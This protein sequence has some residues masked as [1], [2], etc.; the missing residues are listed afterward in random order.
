M[1][2]LAVE[3]H[4]HL[5]PKIW[6]GDKLKSDIET[7]LKKIADV[8]IDWCEVPMKVKEILFLGS[9]ANYNWDS[10]SDIDVHILIDLKSF[11][12][13]NKEIAHDFFELK[14]K[15]FKDLFP[16][17]VFGIPVE[18]TVEDE[19]NPY[20]ADGVY[21][22]SKG[23][24]KHEPKFS[25]PDYDKAKAKAIAKKWKDTIIG[26]IKNSSFK[27][28][29][30]I[31]DDLKAKRKASLEKGG[32]FDEFNVAFKD[33]RRRGYVEK[34]KKAGEDALTKELTLK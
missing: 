7:R 17:K 28:L 21:S 12:A 25:P 26:A 13:E 24:W 4:D 9:N 6:D 16:I 20:V 3:Y 27:T 10:D 31:K 14:N 11:K 18:I 32:E 15:R 2:D 19:S 8:F 34:L 30:K 22:L 1:T 5:N 29:D 33:V 23:K